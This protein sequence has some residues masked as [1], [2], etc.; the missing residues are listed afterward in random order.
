MS[1]LTEFIQSAFK[2]SAITIGS[3]KFSIGTGK[4]IDIVPAEENYERDY[5][6]QGYDSEATLT[7]VGSS[8]DFRLAYPLTPTD[9]HGKLCL[10]KESEWRVGTINIG[11]QFVT[12]NLVSTTQSA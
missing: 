4:E 7:I 3:K 9:Y 5:E 2:S 8:I 6:M 10:V 1:E 12:I 11:D